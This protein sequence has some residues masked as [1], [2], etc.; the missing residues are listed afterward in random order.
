MPTT[1]FGMPAVEVE[2]PGGEVVKYLIK[3]VPALPGA[4]REW[5]VTSPDGK[6]YRVTEP[7]SGRW[8]CTCKW[9]VHRGRYKVMP[10]S[11]Y[12]DKHINAVR[13]SM[14]CSRGDSNDGRPR[15][16]LAGDGRGGGLPPDGGQDP[17]AADPGG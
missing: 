6:T 11:G 12:H 7:P 16:G 3:P 2:Q 5:L 9:W 15:Q 17:A 1:L 4:W 10:N 14:G 13:D 8:E